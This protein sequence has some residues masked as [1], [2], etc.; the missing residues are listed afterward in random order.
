MQHDDIN[1]V[2]DQLY[3]AAHEPALWV[4]ALDGLRR[5]FGGSQACLF[6][7]EME[8]GIPAHVR[9]HP[10][11]DLDD[12]YLDIL[13]CGEDPTIAV[14]ASAASGH[15]FN[16]LALLPG[17]SLLASRLWTEWLEPQ[18]MRYGLGCKCGGNGSSSWML[19]ISRTHRQGDFDDVALSMLTAL[20]PHLVRLG[21]LMGMLERER[22]LRTAGTDRAFIVRPDMSVVAMTEKAETL[23]VAADGP[24]R[25]AGNRLALRDRRQAGR[26]R[27][28]IEDA[29]RL[30]ETISA[31]TGGE[32]LISRP[33][34]DGRAQFVLTVAP[35]H[36]PQ[37]GLISL[38]QCAAIVAHELSPPPP[39]E[40]ARQ[41]C[42]L[43]GLTRQEARLASLLVAG[44]TLREAATNIGIRYS[45]ARSYIE[46]I[47]QKTGTRQQSQLAALLTRAHQRSA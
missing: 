25:L 34:A 17:N 6:R 28:L 2:L 36:N 33:D 30:G 38:G 22:A 13:A 3:E 37:T 14:L 20:S 23:T 7:Q 8:G 21:R 1:W 42:M 9:T 40:P 47:F 27:T 5:L 24:F 39:Q 4:S 43:F 16:L 41:A 44:Q 26:F 29:C 15:V 18:D 12:T 46:V 45:T 31:G 32:L 10:Y 11:P 19:N 35:T